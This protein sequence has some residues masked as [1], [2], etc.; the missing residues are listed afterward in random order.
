MNNFSFSRHR[1]HATLMKSF[2]LTITALFFLC[3]IHFCL[4]VLWTKGTLDNHYFNLSKLGLAAQTIGVL[5]QVWTVGLL[6]L[7]L[8]SVQT[9]AADKFIRRRKSLPISLISHIPH[10]TFTGCRT[11]CPGHVYQTISFHLQYLR[12]YSQIFTIPLALYLVSALLC[13]HC[14]VVGETPDVLFQLL[15]SCICFG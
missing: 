9:I 6:S 11:N 14:G 8:F 3:A 5:S 13:E 2:L 10:R 4:V 7:L 15:R 12:S 1:H